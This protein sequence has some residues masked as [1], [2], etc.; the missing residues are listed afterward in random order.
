MH[1]DRRENTQ[2]FLAA[3]NEVPKN[4]LHESLWSEL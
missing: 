2:N 1:K 3:I 4:I